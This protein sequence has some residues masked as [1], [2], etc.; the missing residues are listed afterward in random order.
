MRFLM[1]V[2]TDTEAVEA[3][4]TPVPD[5][6]EWASTMD[7][8]GVRITGD[9][10]A[11]ERNAAT[12]RVRGGKKKVTDGP[13]LETKEVLAGFDLLECRDMDEAIEIAAGHPMAY[14]GVIELRPIRE[15]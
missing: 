8:R 3:P 15:L 12:V 14:T 4:T 1:F 7:A 9:A 5:V 6:E 2:C 13:F 11:H 10:L